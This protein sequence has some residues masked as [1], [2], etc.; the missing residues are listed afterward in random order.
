MQT[1]KFDRNLLVNIA[2][3]TTAWAGLTSVVA[4]PALLDPHP[5]ESY[6]LGCLAVGV[7]FPLGLSVASRHKKGNYFG[8]F[9]VDLFDQV[10]RCGKDKQR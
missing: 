2:K 5:V 8:K 6:I 4:L 10:F 9:Y 3:G 1:Q 7:V